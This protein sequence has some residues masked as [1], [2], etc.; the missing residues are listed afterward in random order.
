MAIFPISARSLATGPNNFGPANIPVGSNKVVLTLDVAQM[1]PGMLVDVLCEVWDGVRW[2]G[3]HADFD[4]P[5]R[6][7]QNVLHNEVSLTFGLGFRNG[8][9][10]L[11]IAG[12]QVR[13]VF[14]VTNGPFNTAGGTL[15][16]T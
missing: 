4:G 6:D 5:W 16:V 9:P 7:K 12:W 11:S 10:V 14:T 2:S 3:F 1:T 8:Q 13:A 15:E